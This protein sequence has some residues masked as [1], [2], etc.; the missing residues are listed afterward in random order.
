MAVVLIAVGV[1]QSNARDIEHKFETS[2][3]SIA[4][5]SQRQVQTFVDERMRDARFLA[6]NVNLRAALQ[7]SNSRPVGQW[8][9]RLNSD[10]QAILQNHQYRSISIL[11]A[12]RVQRFGG[13]QIEPLVAPE[14]DALQLVLAQ[15]TESFVD[16][17]VASD[18]TPCFGVAYPV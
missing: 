6:T 10:L 3:Q 11:D 17:H 5:A 1:V 18:G 4:M 16:M 8:E 7:S 13:G 9:S 15:G 14:A 2:L 12:Q